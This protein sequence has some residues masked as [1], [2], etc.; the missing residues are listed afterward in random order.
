MRRRGFVGVCVLAIVAAV[1]ALAVYASAPA[2]IPVTGGAA[3]L[4]RIDVARLLPGTARAYCYQDGAGRKLRF[5]LARGADGKVGTVFDACRQCY[6]FHRGYEVVGN[7]LICRVCGNRY[8][9]Q[10]MTKGKASCVPA[11]LAHETT[12]QIVTIKVS[13]LKSGRALF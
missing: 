12:G 8:R 10:N 2:C 7:E 5:L 1:G 6:M 3:G 11:A 9:I 4:I 13:D